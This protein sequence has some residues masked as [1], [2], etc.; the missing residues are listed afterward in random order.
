MNNFLN[1]LPILMGIP[2]G[3][4]AASAGG[5]GQLITTVVTFGLVILV[6]YFLIIRPRRRKT[7]RV[8]N[9]GVEYRDKNGNPMT[10]SQLFEGKT[11]SQI[12]A[13]KLF[14]DIPLESGCFKKV[15]MSSSDYWPIVKSQI[16]A[17]IKE[18]A[19][20]SL[21]IDEEMVKEIDPVRFEGFRFD[22]AVPHYEKWN[23]NDYSSS[24]YEITWIFFGDEQ[25]YVYKYRFDTTDN[26][27]GDS[28]QEYFYTDIT[29][30]TASSD[31]IEKKLPYIE[32]TGC[33]KNRAER[34]YM[35]RVVNHNLFKII[36]PGD[37]YLCAAQL[38]QEEKQYI[39]AMKQKLREKKKNEIA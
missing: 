22:D 18:K 1:F 32:M 5:A 29:S 11:D 33:M 17:N 31:S 38:S 27:K 19:M 10:E 4:G 30:F 8:Y 7:G 24:A 35:N 34:K 39:S 21:G 37:A 3:G 14:H 2:G 28:N 36:V 23:E 20:D 6:F 12:R 9:R 15:Y 13:L 26:T 25:V 16:P